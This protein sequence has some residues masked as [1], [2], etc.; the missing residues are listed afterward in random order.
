MILGFGRRD[1]ADGL[2]QSTMV[3]PVDPFERVVRDGFEAAPGSATVDH[4]GFVEAVDRLRQSIVAAVADTADRRLDAGLGEALSV[5]RHVLGGCNR[6]SHA[7]FVYLRKALVKRLGWCF[8]A[9]RL[10]WA[11]IE[12]RDNGRKCVG[13]MR[14]EVGAFREILAQQPVSVLVRATLPRALRIA[15][16]DFDAGFDP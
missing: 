9:Q 10:A 6:S 12:G 7:V 16:I 3:E 11:A 15:E 2:Q 13:A 5:D 4:L 8:L 14:A 1:V